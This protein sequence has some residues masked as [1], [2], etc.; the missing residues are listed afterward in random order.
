M[1]CPGQEPSGEADGA[2]ASAAGSVGGGRA[3]GDTARHDCPGQRCAQR[4]QVAPAHPSPPSHA[5][6]PAHSSHLP[7]CLPACP[8][9]PAHHPA[10]PA[11]G[12]WLLGGALGPPEHRLP[13]RLGA[14]RPRRPVPSQ[15]RRAGRPHQG[16]CV[17]SGGQ[18]ARV[19][20]QHTSGDGG[21]RWAAGGRGAVRAAVHSGAAA[22][23]VRRGTAVTRCTSSHSSSRRSTSRQ[24]HSSST[25]AVWRMPRCYGRAACVAAW[26]TWRARC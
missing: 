21:Q 2:V 5:C 26:P 25:R 3:A 17:P 1:G 18:P 8:A 24:R 15:H 11:E 6:Q 9:G 19:S 12:V 4:L 23:A 14:R 10:V 22:A 16:C 20:P 13:A 7:T